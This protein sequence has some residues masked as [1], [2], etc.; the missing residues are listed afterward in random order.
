MYKVIGMHLEIVREGR[1]DPK[2]FSFDIATQP[3]SAREVGFT[4]DFLSA[5][6]PDYLDLFAEYVESWNDD[7]AQYIT[8][9]VPEEAFRA[10]KAWCSDYRKRSAD[11]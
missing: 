10:W 8:P 5:R 1:M 2:K 9:P 6:V 3:Q 4:L 7:F 11:Q